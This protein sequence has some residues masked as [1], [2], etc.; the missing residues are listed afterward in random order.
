MR[1]TSAVLLGAVFAVAGVAAG[2]GLSAGYDTLPQLPVVW[3]ITVGVIAL[4]VAFLAWS[5]RNRVRGERDARPPDP[6]TMARY[7][8]LARACSPVGAGVAGA[9]LGALVALLTR[10]GSSVAVSHDR[11]VSIAGLVTG[12]AL[13][14][15]GLWLEWVCR[16]RPDD[17][18]D[19]R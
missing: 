4:L 17:D 19:R 1:P 11:G 16:V 13:A 5:T 15:A 7:A 2:L 18:R 6:L 8:A 9:W 3:A 10:N 14:A 12:L